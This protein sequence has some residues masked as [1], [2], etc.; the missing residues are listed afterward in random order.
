MRLTGQQREDMAATIRRFD[1]D[2]RGYL[3]GSRVD[4]SKRGGDIDLLILSDTLKKDQRIDIRAELKKRLGQQ[5]IDIV[6]AHDL[7]KPFTRIAI[8]EAVPL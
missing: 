1:P 6:I 8:Q 4:D 3:F 7:S 5:K 2:A